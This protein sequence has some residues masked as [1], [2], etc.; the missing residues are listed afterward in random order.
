MDTHEHN[1]EQSHQSAQSHQTFADT[2]AKSTALVYKNPS[3]TQIFYRILVLCSHTH[4]EDA[5]TQA[6]CDFP[7]MNVP[8][9]TPRFFLDELY[10]AGALDRTPIPVV[11][12]SDEW[13]DEDSASADSKHSKSFSMPTTYTWCT[14]DVGMRLIKDIS[15]DARLHHLMAQEKDISDIYRSV[16][17]FCR[18]PKTRMQ[19]ENFVQHNKRVQ[20][21]EVMTSFFLDRLERNGG[22]V[23]NDGWKT[24]SAGEA[25]THKNS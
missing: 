10:N 12:D 7:E 16:L 18:T 8:L 21:L 22:L 1:P 17:K 20:G 6:I 13:N 25:L 24:T 19:V 9:H 2:Y 23:W 4:D 15:P 3:H 5:V 14:N 11:T